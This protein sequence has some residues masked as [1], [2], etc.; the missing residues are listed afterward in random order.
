[1]QRTMPNLN[2]LPTH[3]HTRKTSHQHTHNA[4]CLINRSK[5]FLNF[6]GDPT[7]TDQKLSDG[8][9]LKTS[10]TKPASRPSSRIIRSISS[11]Q[12]F[13]TFGLFTP[14]LNEAHESANSS[15]SDSAQ[16]ISMDGSMDVSMDV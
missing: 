1:M 6:T 12:A 4:R 9:H 5:C 11:I 15:Q 8:N 13:V 10:S 2:R 7:F 3:L 16:D 14:E